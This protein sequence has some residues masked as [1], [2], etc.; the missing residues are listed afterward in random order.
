M[1]PTTLLLILLLPALL[2]AQSGPEVGGM[3]AETDPP[4]PPDLKRVCAGLPAGAMLE[5]ALADGASIAD[6]WAGHDGGRTVQGEVELGARLGAVEGEPVVARQ[7]SGPQLFLAIQHCCASSQPTSSIVC[8]LP[9]DGLP[10]AE[11]A[12]PV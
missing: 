11:Y 6:C 8:P 9:V 12:P 3:P 5:I 2:R 4:P 1:R 7:P 10:W